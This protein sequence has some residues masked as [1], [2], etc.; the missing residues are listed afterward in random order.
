MSFFL[1]SF[2]GYLLLIALA[3]FV[4]ARIAQSELKPA[5]RQAVED[6]L[7][8]SANL[9]AEVAT[10]SA[11]P[12]EPS[13]AAPKL[14]T[15]AYGRFEQRR[16]G[17]HIY[18]IEKSTPELRLY[19][20]DAQG[21]VQFDSVRSNI[22]ADF[23]TWNDVG[24]TLRGEYGARAT[25]A[26]ADNPATSVMHVAAPLLRDGNIV[27]VLSLGKSSL[28]FEPFLQRSRGEILQAGSALVAAAVVIALGLSWWVSFDL[29][30]LSQ[31]ARDAGA[32]L[33]VAAPRYRG[34]ELATLAG[35]LAQMRTE[36]EGKAHVEQYAQLLTHELK[37]PLAAIQGAAELLNE[38]MPRADRQRFVANIRAQTEHM[39]A[40]VE[41]LLQLAVLENRQALT[42]RQPVAL[43]EL[44][45]RVARSRAAL[46]T[47]KAV[48][49]TNAVPDAVHV[50]GESM[51]LQLAL[52][53]L[54]DNALAF[55]DS[56]GA[57][58][59]SHTATQG[60]D[61]I[62]VRDHGAGLPPYA[63]ARLFERFY[64]L[65]RPDTGLK[66]TGLGLLL[67]REVADLHGGSI[68][69]RNHPDGGVEASLSVPA[70]PFT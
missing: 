8:D 52:T 21:R 70:A 24:R 6:L 42:Q 27:G 18:G 43:R 35:A 38:D 15:D 16:F 66:S 22:G 37:S 48:T 55:S 61:V 3:A 57:I 53:N 65:P 69:V 68:S 50:Q 2:A 7:V 36:L 17:A 34:G 26:V 9:L 60:Q 67:V 63:Q 4:G 11:V 44:V 54:L 14:L 20:T 51:L 41:R 46:L 56:G 12:D 32:G 45:E 58:E 33:R 13:A 64:S 5:M 30:R 40:L 59:V 49:L 23:S 47:R 25:R 62:C 28:S 10:G 1:R 19:L 39:Q 29:R 31:F